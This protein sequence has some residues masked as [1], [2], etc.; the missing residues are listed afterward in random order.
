[1]NYYKKKWKMD[2]L[3]LILALC[4]MVAA[5]I[6]LL[7]ALLCGN[8]TAA[9]FLACLAALLGFVAAVKCADCGRSSARYEMMRG[10]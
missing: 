7:V 2:C 9:I 5:M 1:M 3:R 10:E 4:G 8:P 6:W